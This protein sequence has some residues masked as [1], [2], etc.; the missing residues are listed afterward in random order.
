MQVLLPPGWSRPRGYANGV[1]ATGRMVFV[2]GMVGWDADGRFVSDT[3]AGQARQALSNIVAVL[4]VAGTKP[5][6]IVR[7]TWYVTDKR[8]YVA[9]YPGDRRRVPRADRQLQRGDDGGAG[10]RAD[11]RPGPG[12][13]RSHGGDP[14]VMSGAGWIA[15]RMRDNSRRRGAEDAEDAEKNR[16][17]RL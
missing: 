8:A 3:L 4:K 7:M 1:A 12:R 16:R 17:Q 15:F 11:R 2:A 10:H 13:D 9:A 14:G 6:H 5:E